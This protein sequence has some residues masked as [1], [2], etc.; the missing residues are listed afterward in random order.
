MFQRKIYLDS[1]SYV[2]VSTRVYD[3]KEQIM[4]TIAGKKNESEKVVSSAI[5]TDSHASLFCKCL[6]DAL[7]RNPSWPLQEGAGE[8]E[9]N[10][11]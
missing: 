10:D 11:L 3:G 1:D 7:A 4:I 5:M 8:E 6:Q 9:A 2:E